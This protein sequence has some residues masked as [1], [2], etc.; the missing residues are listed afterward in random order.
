M[1]EGK[2]GKGGNNCELKMLI[3]CSG[4][5]EFVYFRGTLNTETLA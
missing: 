5:D 3:L 2:F 4:Y 1:L